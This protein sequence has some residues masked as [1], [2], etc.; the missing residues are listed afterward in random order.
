MFNQNLKKQLNKLKD[1][2][3]LQPDEQWKEESKEELMSKIS[4]EQKKK[5]VQ[6]VS[7]LDK[8]TA[9]F[10]ILLPEKLERVA[11]KTAMGI[12]AVVLAVGGWTGA[13]QASH[14]SVPGDTLYKVKMASE[15][16]QLAVTEVVGSK[17][18][19]AKLH[20]KFAKRRAEEVQKI[21]TNK[22]KKDDKQAEQA[23]NRMNNS[24]EQAQQAITKSDQSD[25]TKTSKTKSKPNTNKKADSTQK[26]LNNNELIVE[27]L[28]NTLVDIK[29]NSVDL[30][31]EIAIVKGE[32]TTKSLNLLEYMVR[33][34]LEGRVN[35]SRAEIRALVTETISQLSDSSVKTTSADPLGDKAIKNI[36]NNVLNQ[37]E[38]EKKKKAD[39]KDDDQENQSDEDEK[40]EDPQEDKQKEENNISTSSTT[41][42]KNSTTTTD[43]DSAT[44][45][46]KTET[47]TTSSTTSS[48]TTSASSSAKSSSTTSTTGTTKSA[49]SSKSLALAKQL[50]EKGNL[51]QAINKAK[52]INI[53]NTKKLTDLV[54]KIAVEKKKNNQDKVHVKLKEEGKEVV[55]TSVKLGEEKNDKSEEPETSTKK[56]T[57]STDKTKKQEKEDKNST[58]TDKTNKQ[59][60]TSTEKTNTTSTT[61]SSS[62][63]DET[64]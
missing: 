46:D 59:T 48:S 47:T 45:T 49:S 29:N 31:S 3:S 56:K 2:E 58:S 12:G 10:D 37:V 42:S 52:N 18:E 41:S 25:K 7:L 24:I 1:H 27:T 8:I 6:N 38:Q 39:Q 13:V 4:S 53:K 15:Q 44:S 43:T 14:S 36:T 35:L 30:A 20:S 32:V 57:T 22:N 21:V 61:S 11:R 63:K 54:H 60:E 5:E 33:G 17:S 40:K 16:A 50:A 34:Q 51:L 9:G 55:T 23:I 19:E 28:S 26:I 64:E 62:P